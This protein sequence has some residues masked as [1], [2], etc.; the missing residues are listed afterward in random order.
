M[1]DSTALGMLKSLME[2]PQKMAKMSSGGLVAATQ[3][4]IWL[5]PDFK[6]ILHVCR[7]SLLGNGTM[8]WDTNVGQHLATF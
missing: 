2:V 6:H 7:G 3:Q 1:Q 4:G 5:C 8:F